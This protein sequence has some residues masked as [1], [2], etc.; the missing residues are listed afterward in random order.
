MVITYKVEKNLSPEEFIGVLQR[1]TLGQRRPVSDR[2]RIQ[3]M[4]DNADIMMCARDGAKLIGISRAV[5]D[6]SYC[7]YLSDLAVDVA[8]QKSGIGQE[9]VKRT[10]ETAGHHTKL[11]LTSVSDA[12]AFTRR[13]A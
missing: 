6:F 7:C 13:L 4:L 12:M 8:Y 2:T 5:T 9:L 10:H 11:L 3:T 1:T